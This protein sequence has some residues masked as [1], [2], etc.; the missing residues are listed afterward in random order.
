MTAPKT[1]GEAAY[2]GFGPEHRDGWPLERPWRKKQWEAAA[3]AA[4]AQHEATHGGDYCY[5][6][7][8]EVDAWQRERAE[9]KAERDALAA[10][11]AELTGAIQE[12]LA[13]TSAD[14]PIEEWVARPRPDIARRN[15]RAALTEHEKGGT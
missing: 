6:P 2:R 9:L 13:A 4:I 14:V 10:R 3:A 11:V 12:Y 8:A 5:V 15:L 1:P 7:R